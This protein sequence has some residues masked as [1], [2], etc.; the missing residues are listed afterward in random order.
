MFDI[1]IVIRSVFLNYYEVFVNLSDCM[2]RHLLFFLRLHTPAMQ[3]NTSWRPAYV[4]NNTSWDKITKV[5]ML[6]GWE[7]PDAMW[8]AL[9]SLCLLLE[10]MKKVKIAV[11]IHLSVSLKQTWGLQIM[12]GVLLPNT[13]TNKS[14]V[15]TGGEESGCLFE[16]QD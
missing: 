10:S 1:R 14:K 12:W 15:L 4:Y 2:T 3:E 9:I 5:W 6:R 11:S 13:Q 16:K 7:I 8:N